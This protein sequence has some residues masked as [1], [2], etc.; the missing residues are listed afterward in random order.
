MVQLHRHGPLLGGQCGQEGSET[1]IPARK[2]QG[3]VTARPHSSG[4]GG[5]GRLGVHVSLAC[6]EGCAHF[7][8]VSSCHLWGLVPHHPHFGAGVAAQRGSVICLGL[9][10]SSGAGSGL[11]PGILAP[12]TVSEALAPLSVTGSSQGRALGFGPAGP[13]AELNLISN[14]RG[15]PGPC[16]LSAAVT[17][18]GCSQPFGAPNRWRVTGKKGGQ[19]AIGGSVTGA[20]PGSIR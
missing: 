5:S 6:T 10:S 13:G 9:H 17:V 20:P 19:E 11:P 3:G 15:N 8:Q 1:G 12:G 14:T 7:S 4:G 18:E 2:G 16:P